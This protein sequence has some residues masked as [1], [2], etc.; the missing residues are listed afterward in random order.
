MRMT[1]QDFLRLSVS[2]MNLG[3]IIDLVGAGILF[4]AGQI[5]RSQGIVEPVDSE[6]IGTLGYVLLAISAAELLVLLRLKSR[7][8]KPSGYPLERRNDRGNFEGQ[9]RVVFSIMYLIALS[10]AIYGFLYYMLGGT[11]SLFVIFIVITL[12]GYM[13]A[14]VKPRDLERAF[15]EIDFE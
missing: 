2:L 15:G 5:L 7:Y 10:P 6:A 8:T 14:R 11:E 13:I 1:Q 9:L 3:L 4:V 12:V